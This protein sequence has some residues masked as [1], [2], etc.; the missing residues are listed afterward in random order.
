MRYLTLLLSYQM[1]NV[2]SNVRDSTTQ[3]P[4][5][6]QLVSVLGLDS[7]V[8]WKMQLHKDTLIQTLS[9]SEELD[10]RSKGKQEGT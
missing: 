10:V 6:V 8:A 7:N 4:F 9:E 2:W 3:V 5:N 1:L